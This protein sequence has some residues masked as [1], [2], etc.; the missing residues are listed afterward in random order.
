MKDSENDG[1]SST[2]EME[3]YRNP[4]TKLLSTLLQKG[5]TMDPRPNDNSIS[6]ISSIDF[7]APKISPS[8]SLETLAAAL[9]YELTQRQW[10]VTGQV[11]PAYFSEDFEFQDPDVKVSGIEEYSKGVYKLFDQA[12]SKAEIISTVINTVTSTPARPVITCTWRLSGGVNIAFG[13]KIKPYVVYTDFVVDPNTSLIVF[14][15]DRF[16]VP[17]WDI[18]L[19]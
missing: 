2:Q 12:I 4:I 13:L 8:T 9:D 10:F 6:P 15:E 5:D 3:E 14:Q 11:N 19:R 7:S 18:L 16:D 17:A 1:G